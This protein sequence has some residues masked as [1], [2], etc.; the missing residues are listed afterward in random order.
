VREDWIWNVILPCAAH[1]SLIVAA[2]LMRR[3]PGPGLIGIAA[4]SML[5]LSTGIHNAWDI[6]V[7]KI[8][9]KGGASR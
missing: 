7:W 5:L 6:A 3:R 8:L 1:A 4:A 9:N 2:F